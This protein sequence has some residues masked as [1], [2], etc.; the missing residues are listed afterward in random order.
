MTNSVV[1]LVDIQIQN[2]KNV[3][4]GHLN[5]INRRKQFRA[6]V[7]GLYGQNGPGRVCRISLRIILTW[8]RRWHVYP[9]I[10]K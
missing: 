1:R 2:F 4:N 7:L 10:S 5:L 3:K 6:S 9:F 8:M